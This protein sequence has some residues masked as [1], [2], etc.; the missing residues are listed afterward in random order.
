ML[1]DV[2]GA[3]CCLQVFLDDGFAITTLVQLNIKVLELMNSAAK[4]PVGVPQKFELES[5]A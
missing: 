1:A 4:I 5:L 2:L 3:S